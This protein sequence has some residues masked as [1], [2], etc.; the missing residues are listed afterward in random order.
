M[1][2]SNMDFTMT[3]CEACGKVSTQNE[4]MIACD[5]CERWYHSRCVEVTVAT[6]KDTK[7]FCPEDG[8]QAV[9]QSYQKQKKANRSK[10]NTEESDRSSAK[11]LERQPP[12]LPP[13]VAAKIRAMEAEKK[14]LEEEMDA[15]CLLREKEIEMKNALKER[16]MRL[17]RE[18]REKELQKDRELREREI[19]EK[20]LQHQRELQEKK[21]HLCHIRKMEE[22]HQDQMSF[23]EEQLKEALMVNS[24]QKTK[25]VADPQ[26]GFSG[27]SGGKSTPLRPPAFG[28]LTEVNL[29]MFAQNAEG[30]SDEENRSDITDG[31][32]GCDDENGERNRRPIVDT[33]PYGLGQQRAGPSRAQL[34]ARSGLTKKLP[35]FSGKPEEWPLFFGAYQ[36]SNEAC[37][38]SDVENLVRLQDCLKGS[39]LESVRGQLLLPK[40]VPRVI[41]K[42]RQLYGRPEQLL[43]SHLEKVRRLEPPKAE[44]LASFIPFGN[45][46]EQLCEHLEAAE[47][48]LHLVNPI[49]IQDLVGKLP[50]GE[51]RQWVQYKRKKN[52]VTLRTFTDFISRIVADACEANVTFEYKP[53]AR[54]A[55][56]T[57]GRSKPK[58]KAALYSHSEVECSSADG[59]NRAQQKPCKVCHR[60]D[61]RVRFCQDFK[62]L[63]YGDRM[64]IVTRWK[65]CKVCLNEHGGQCRFKIRCNVG[66]CRELHNP[67]VHPVT[68]VVG[69]SAHILSSS[70]VLF[71]MVPVQVHCGG[72][73]VTVLAFLDEGAS[74]TLIENNL[75][76]R[77]GLVGVQEKLTIKWTADVTRV[78]KSSRRMSVWTSA[79]GG[80]SR[81]KFLLHSVRTVER[82]L[83]PHQT[84]NAE[85]LSAKYEHIRGLAISSYDG[86]PEILIGLNNIH[87]FAPIEAKAGTTNE[88]IAVRCKLGW[89]IY[90]PRQADSALTGSYLGY[91]Q[92]VSNEAIHDLLKSHYALEESVVSVQQESVEDQRARS[93]LERTTKRVGNRFETG[94]LWKMDDVHFPDSYPMALKRTKQLERKLEKSPE[95]YQNIRDQIKRYLENVYAHLA[96]ESE[97]VSTECDKVWYLPLNIVLNPKKPNKVRIV[98][99]AAATVQGVSLNSMLLKGPD[100]LVPLVSVII[101]FR[102]RRIAFGGDIREM[103][104]QLKIIPGDKQA[105]RFLFRDNSSEPP[106]VYVMDVA[107]FGSTCSPASAQ[108]IKNRNA[109]EHAAQYPEAAGAIINRH[110][111]DDYFDSVDTVEEAV[112]RAKQ[113]SHI[114]KQA[115]FEIR[116]WVSN[117]PEFLSALGEEKPM[118]PVLFNQDK[119]ACSERVLGVFWDP[120]RDVF[121]FNIKH[122]EDIKAYLY[123]G[124]RPT[125]RIVLSCVMGF[126]DPLGLLSPF[127]IHGKV[128]I[129]H[130]WRNGCEWDQLIDDKAWLKWK[131][132]T[133]LLPQVEALRIPRCYLGD[134]VSTSVDS[135][136]LHIFTDA[137]EH[138]YGCVAYLRAVVNGSVQCSLVMSRAKVA[139]LKRQSIPRLELMAAVLGARMSQTILSSHNLQIA[140]TF[141]WTDSRTVL[142][143][144]HSDTH[145]YKQFVA[146]RVGEILDLTRLVDWY[147]VPSKQNAA[148]VLTKWGR[149]PPLQNDAEWKNGS[150]FLY[151]SRDQWPCTGRIDETNEEARGVVLCHAVVDAAA[152]SRWVKLVRVTATAVR[153]IANIQR[154]K[155]GLPTVTSKAT[156]IQHRHIKAE[157]LTVQKPL[158][159]EELREA[160]TILWKQVQFD[161][162]P[163]E[164]SA[165]MKNLQHKPDLPLAKI[166]KSSCLYKLSPVLDAEGVLRVRGRLEKNESIPFDKRYPIILSR[167]HE[168]TKKLILHFHEKYGHANRETVF[169][170]LRQKFW[171]PNARAAIQ[172]V[173]KECVWCKVNRCVPRIPMMAPL[174]VQ[175]ITPHLRPF[176][177][178]G[179]DYLGPV[180]VTVGRRKEKRWIAV[181]TCMAIRAVHLEIVH[182]LTTQSCLM[183]IRRFACK[184]GAPEQIFSDNATCFH[185]ADIVMKKAMEKIN[186]ECAEKVS[187]TA[188]A[189]LFNPPGTPHMGGVWERMVRSIKEAL[190]VLDDGQKLTDEILST[191]LA[192]AEDIINTR[193]LTYIP[194]ESAEEEAITPNH[195]LR[196]TVTSADVRM[197]DSVGIA[198]ALRNNY[199]RSQYLAN[200]LWERWSKEYL[201]TLNHRPKW[202]EDRKPLQVGDLVFVVDGKNRKNWVRGR[203]QE[204]VRG[205]DG[206]IRQA[207]V[208]TADG[209][210]HRRAVVNL[211]VLEIQDGKSGNSGEISGCYGLGYVDTA[212]QSL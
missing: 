106:K 18:L 185:G 93:I 66:D 72:R 61:H 133:D 160:E 194:Q 142:S 88:P 167:K 81:D 145:G 147:W 45:A 169:N 94:L 211:A 156:K 178:V 75:A 10:K 163:D 188:T 122:R 76:N 184:R 5:S 124:E 68:S 170:E 118:E 117:S 53:D 21:E 116:N 24:G 54:F 111:V 126:F 153:F 129:Q 35:T 208:R 96:T 50:D 109:E 100:L 36:A 196:G 139:P 128:I 4:E 64:K 74:V 159:Q 19:E 27:A 6:K 47:L 99:D 200:R 57:S 30:T 26:E 59:S 91:H 137:S 158:Q 98:W 78:E 115:G 127:T 197:G 39:A 148:D 31:D 131:Q 67:L 23:V 28:K 113:V 173:T 104:H 8:C 175:R 207:D 9:S 165:L 32:E 144:L 56:G 199:K 73:S 209:K 63:S 44:K 161:S 41:A 121:A 206:R 210:V 204:V 203:I 182:S 119:Q 179:V 13:S 97:L 120:E 17:D 38:Y 135:L 20:R 180:E 3:P 11:S 89:T 212:G 95:L 157:Y 71:R 112:E 33:T 86:R 132:W 34:A 65:L 183:A 143:W 70:S 162:F 195:F 25:S 12:T 42:L 49:L 155:A 2:E 22:I 51:K 16:R 103:Y 87:S 168:I 46:V 40:S 177:A 82:M 29:K 201:P 192:E 152:V 90:G 55:A 101:G 176:S 187:S 123:D 150:Y 186:S 134:A 171:I 83:L 80:T 164:M 14:R 77:L 125:K 140:R 172:Q 37:G 85:E 110:Y 202:I 43:Q 141:L 138:A 92:E 154:K 149:G 107:T 7:W 102:Q 166:E 114:H 48:T 174:P 151:Q 15:E 205:A 189:W 58:E 108:Y 130:L 191:T 190:R 136:E 52:P 146:F 84:L 1:S 69:M 181:F 60:T 105:Q 79:V 198:D 62:D 193:P